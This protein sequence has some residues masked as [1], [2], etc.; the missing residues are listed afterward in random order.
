MSLK[1]ILKETG[2]V[3]VGWVHLAQGRMLWKA[4]VN[5]LINVLVP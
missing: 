4:L 3:E 1:W 5:M 2:F